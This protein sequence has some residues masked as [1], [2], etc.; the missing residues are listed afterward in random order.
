MNIYLENARRLI[1]YPR[2]PRRYVD[3]APSIDYL[4]D[5]DRKKRNDD[6]HKILLQQNPPPNST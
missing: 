3:S 1:R 5:N 6:G 2:Q 4:T